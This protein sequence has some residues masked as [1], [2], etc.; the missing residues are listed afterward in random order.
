MYKEYS[1]LV[2]V[3]APLGTITV[4]SLCGKVCKQM[5]LL[6]LFLFPLC[7]TVSA[8]SSCRAQQSSYHAIISGLDR[9]LDSALATPGHERF[10]F[11]ASI[12]TNRIRMFLECLTL[13]HSEPPQASYGW[14]KHKW[15]IEYDAAVT[16]AS[17]CWWCV[18]VSSD[19]KTFSL[20]RNFSFLKMFHLL[21][22]GFFSSD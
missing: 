13:F 14:L 17:W 11:S 18:L 20:C 9:D 1:Q 3:E 12:V 2:W 16:S 5:C 19:L 10:W 8:Q 6:Q 4:L 21:S 15:W 7:K 22:R